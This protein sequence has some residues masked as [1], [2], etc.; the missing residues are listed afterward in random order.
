MSLQLT[1]KI[2]YGYPVSDI[3]NISEGITDGLKRINFF[4][5]ARPVYKAIGKFINDGL[6]NK[7][8]ITVSKFY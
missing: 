1:D 7:S 5:H 4:R 6:T 3:L 8:E 2:T